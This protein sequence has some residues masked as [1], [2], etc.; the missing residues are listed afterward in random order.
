MKD[1]LRNISSAFLTVEKSVMLKTS[2]LSPH[3][4]SRWSSL[5]VQTVGQQFTTQ[6]WFCLWVGYC[7]LLLVEEGCCC[8][9][10]T[11]TMTVCWS[12]F[13][14]WLLFL[15]QNNNGL[16]LLSNWYLI[17][18]WI[19]KVWATDWKFLKSCSSTRSSGTCL[20]L[21]GAAR[22]ISTSDSPLV[23][24]VAW[25]SLTSYQKACVGSYLIIVWI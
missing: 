25:T 23:A 22:C 10:I 9:T 20:A 2:L 4:L 14:P 11:R 3:S 21:D 8:R 6:P 12:H 13:Q 7:T 17:Y 15:W 19:L 18:F 16:W 5:S 24:K 1:A